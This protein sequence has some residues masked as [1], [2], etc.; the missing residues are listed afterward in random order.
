MVE[1]EVLP[2]VGIPDG[3]VKLD[4]QAAKCPKTLFEEEQEWEMK[5]LFVNA[6]GIGTDKSASQP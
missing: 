6:P 1:R 2:A 5:R 4:V 3:D